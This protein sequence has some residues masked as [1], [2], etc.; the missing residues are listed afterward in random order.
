MLAR[1]DWFGGNYSS[2]FENDEQMMDYFRQNPV[3][4]ILWS[5]R[6]N[7]APKPHAVVMKEML[8]R[9]PFVWRPVLLEGSWTIYAFQPEFGAP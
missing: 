8:K 3:N 1:S 2:T 5:E 4:L 6:T 7:L 9:Y